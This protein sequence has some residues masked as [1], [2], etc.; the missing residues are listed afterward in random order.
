MR[1]VETTPRSRATPTTTCS[2]RSAR[3]PMRQATT[4]LTA[5]TSE[6]DD[7]AGDRRSRATNRPVPSELAAD[8]GER[9]EVAQG[10]AQALAEA[11]R[12]LRRR[13]E[14]L[15]QLA[16][17]AR[18]CCVSWS[19]TGGSHSTTPTPTLQAT[20]RSGPA[21]LAA[22]GVHDP[23]DH[24]AQAERD[25]ADAERQVRHVGLGAEGRRGDERDS[26]R[27]SPHEHGP[28][29]QEH[30]DPGQQR[31]VRVPRLGQRQ[32]AVA[33]DD[34]GEQ[35]GDGGHALPAQPAVSDPQRRGD[36]GTWMTTVPASSAHDDEPSRRYV[37]A[38]R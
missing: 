11:D 14:V 37:G 6:R 24:G 10:D 26:I 7:A 22:V 3:E 36:G 13:A 33:A 16:E 34:D 31:Q 29:G 30:E 15:G 4:A 17:V 38:S 8:A 2:E 32:L 35:R 9:V 25:H 1:A 21:A 23:P 18:A 12:R 20:L 28:V 5:H 19:A 27:W